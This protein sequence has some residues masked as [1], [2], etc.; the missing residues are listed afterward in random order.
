MTT[1]FGTEPYIEMA[2]QARL[3]T[4]KS[5]EVFKQG[6]NTIAGNAELLAG[7][8]RID[9]AQSVERYFD[10]LQ[11]AVD[12]MRG[13][14]GQWFSAVDTLSGVVRE[15]AESMGGVV[16]N[17]IESVTDLA[18]YQAA[19]IDDTAREQAE[20]AEQ[21]QKDLARKAKALQR[22]QARKEHEKAREPYQGLTKAELS[23]RLAERD[24]PKTGN[25][26]DLIERLVE[27]D[28]K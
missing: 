25:L 9:L 28:A 11:Q 8:P 26:D 6:A 17:Q 1:T 2:N 22:E 10:F 7:L 19:K 15:Q 14:T 24:L 27:D 20:R 21:A 16:K 13:L 23:D 4:E 12:T 18:A 3:N 5:I